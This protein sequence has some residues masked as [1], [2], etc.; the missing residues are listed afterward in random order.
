MTA[1]IVTIG[2][3]T[4]GYVTHTRTI[5]RVFRLEH[6]RWIPMWGRTQFGTFRLRPDYQGDHESTALL[7]RAYV[8]RLAE[9]E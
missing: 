8:E 4:Y 9:D 6:G 1:R 2:G 5:E 3:V 7:D